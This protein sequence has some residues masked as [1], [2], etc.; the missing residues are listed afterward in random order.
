MALSLAVIF[1]ASLLLDRL[2]RYVKLP[3]LLGMLAVGM[4]CGPYGLNLLSADLLH[5]SADLRRFALI[6]ILL[7][8][9]L[10]ISRKTLNTL[11]GRVLLMG[12]VPSACEGAAVALAAPHLLGLAPAESLLLGAVVAAVSPAV[13]VPAMLNLLHS[14]ET[15]DRTVPTLLL[16]ASPLDNVFVIVVFGSLFAAAKGGGLSVGRLLADLPLSLISGVVVGWLCGEGLYRGFRRFNPR[17]TKR[18]LIV[19]S[20]ALVL[21]SLEETVRIVLPFSGLAAVMALGYILLE[22]SEAFAHEISA[23]LNKI[24]VMA[25]IMLFVLVGAQVNVALAWQAGLWGAAIVLIGL[26]ARSLGVWVALLGSRLTLR[27]RLFCIVAYIPKATVQAV[28]GAVAMSAALPGGQLI[29]AVA[30]VAV[31]ITAP[32]GATGIRLLGPRLLAGTE[33]DRAAQPA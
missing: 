7:R 3:G 33:A 22:R 32:L 21:V 19:V 6:V 26:G 29:L 24:W 13:V 8:A 25:E 11:G 15:R 1:L 10:M 4:V 31:V 9:G 16:A 23:K 2:L 5:V 27:E 18:V 20:L 12:L 30:V 14:Q 17:A 28:V